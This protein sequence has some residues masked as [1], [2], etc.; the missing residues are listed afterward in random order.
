MEFHIHT[1]KHFLA[2]YCTTSV[3]LLLLLPILL[4]NGNNSKVDEETRDEDRMKVIQLVLSRLVMLICIMNILYL[5][6]SG[7][8]HF[9]ILMDWVI[10]ILQLLSI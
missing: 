8:S 6:I 4:Q 1:F 9:V 5:V 3:Q 2:Q 10:L 7:M